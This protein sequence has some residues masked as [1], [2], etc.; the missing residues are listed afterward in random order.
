[1]KADNAAIYMCAGYTSN[2]R[3]AKTFAAKLK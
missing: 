3:D 2:R 1:M